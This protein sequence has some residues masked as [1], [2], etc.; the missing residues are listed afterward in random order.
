M[1]WQAWGNLDPNTGYHTYPIYKALKDAKL[2]RLGFSNPTGE[3]GLKVY[4]A[5]DLD[6]EE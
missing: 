6:I 5:R 3:D 1:F 4:G 2:N